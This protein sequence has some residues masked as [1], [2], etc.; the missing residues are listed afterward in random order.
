MNIFN[1]LL[2]QLVKYD[3][4]TTRKINSIHAIFY[5]ILSLSYVN[6][7]Q[8][9]LISLDIRIHSNIWS[10]SLFNLERG[11]PSSEYKNR[12][13]W[14]PPPMPS[15]DLTITQWIDHAPTLFSTLQMTRAAARTHTKVYFAHTLNS[16]RTLP[17]SLSQILELPL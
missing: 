3:V 17:S 2:P 4:H 7:N 6:Q 15:L 1:S 12:H 10:V 9:T 11:T 14:L 8:L 5:H 13:Q 16:R